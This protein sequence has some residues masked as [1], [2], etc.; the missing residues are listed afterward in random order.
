MVIPD[1]ESVFVNT[2]GVLP[3]AEISRLLGPYENF[4]VSLDSKSSEYLCW[5]VPN[6]SLMAGP[7][8]VA[9]ILR[10]DTFFCARESVTYEEELH[11]ASVM[12]GPTS[13]RVAEYLAGDWF[14]LSSAWSAGFWHWMMEALPRVYLLE[15]SGY[16]GGYLVPKGPR[17]I[18]E[19]LE[20]LGIPDDRVRVLSEPSIQVEV[21]Y[22]MR[23]F[24]GQFAFDDF[25]G[26]VHAIQR[27]MIP[28]ACRKG[29]EPSE[30]RIYIARV[31]TRR[32]V[33][34]PEFMEFLIKRGFNGRY[35][36]ESYPLAEQI[37][38]VSDAEVVIGPHGAGM[39]LTMFMPMNSAVVELFA[40]NYI[41]PCMTSTAR[42]LLQRMHMVVSRIWSPGERYQYGNDIIPDLPTIDQILMTV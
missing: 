2:W 31:G 29:R 36:M 39:A 22:I 32:I 28:A 5:R 40:P 3:I 14:S 23:P 6:A 25:P 17:Y 33:N 16:T 8:H 19:S 12:Q 11:A 37:R 10:G 20:L 42:Q 13:W 4:E 15:S 26:L 38:R 21:L 18:L 30:S 35:L 27:R 7:H 24:L 41:N 34:E 1:S 9:G